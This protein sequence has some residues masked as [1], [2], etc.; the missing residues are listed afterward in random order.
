VKLVD[1]LSS[2]TYR[3]LRV[4]GSP[5]INSNSKLDTKDVSK[6][7]RYAI[8][9]RM[10]LLYLKALRKCGRLGSLEEEYSRLSNRYIKTVE[11]ISRATRV[12]E[13]AGVDYTLFKSIRPYHEVTV[14]VDVLVFGT[15]YEEVI[16]TM[17]DAGYTLLGAGPTTATLRDIE[18]GINVDIY[19]EVAASRVIYLDKDKLR[20]F[21]VDRQLPN[22]EFVGSLDSSAD[23]L[24][25][26]AHSLVKEHMYVLSEYYSTLYY[27][28]DMNSKALDSFLSLV[29]ECRMRSAVKTHLGATALLHYGAH[30]FI[31]I[32]L[33]KLLGE[34]GLN[35]LELS[36]VKE[37]SFR[38]PHKYHP[39]TI[40]R[41]LIEKL[42]ESKAKRSFAWQASSMLN[43]KFTS[44]V[45]RETLSRIF[46]ETY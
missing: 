26:I 6:L 3:I 36:R 8:K 20:R 41:T 14:D 30:A 37:M 12:L 19:D 34:L 33:M 38:M 29:D 7:Y 10:P 17:S 42:G 43:P 44:F 39:L 45:V 31:P 40:T 5:F 21:T 4:I 13:R 25:V 16:S 22:G 11:A 1:S 15:E 2:L 27:L 28:A 46:R 23:L 24:A 35:H 18:A 9:N 32:C